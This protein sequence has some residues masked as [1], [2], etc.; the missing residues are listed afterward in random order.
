MLMKPEKIAFEYANDVVDYV[1]RGMVPS[2]KNF[3][4]I[5]NKVKNPDEDDSITTNEVYI[6]KKI[7]INYDKDTMDITMRRVYENRVRNRNIGIGII[8]AMVL[9]LLIGGIA[10]RSNDHEDNRLDDKYDEDNIRHLID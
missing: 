6:P 10:S 2:R 1:S 3:E 9:G 8:G 5:I 4:K 7:F